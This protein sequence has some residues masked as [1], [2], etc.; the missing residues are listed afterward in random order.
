LDQ[1]VNESTYVLL[2]FRVGYFGSSVVVRFANLSA[3]GIVAEED[4]V[5]LL[6]RGWFG[7]PRLWVPEQMT[8]AGGSLETTPYSYVD[9]Q[10][11]TSYGPTLDTLPTAPNGS[12]LWYG[13]F[14]YGLLPGEYSVTFWVTV[15][16]QSAGP[17]IKLAA[18]G[19]PVS[20]ELDQN[21]ATNEQHSYA[22]LF[23]NGLTS[24]A[25]TTVVSN[26]T[27]GPHSFTENVTMRFRWNELE[28]WSVPGWNLANLTTVRLWSVT[29][30]QLSS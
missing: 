2:D 15:D 19:N 17:Q 6:E 1:F 3:F 24:N 12:I 5:M 22:F 29:L 10:S 30:D 13:P 8:W 16:A 28:I 7:P 11:V 14:L 27:P 20:I 25:T 18:A 9:H 23:S 26:P 4:G 21:G